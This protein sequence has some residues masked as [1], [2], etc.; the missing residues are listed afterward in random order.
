MKNGGRKKINQKEKSEEN[1]T[2]LLAKN[3]VKRKIQ[4]LHDPSLSFFLF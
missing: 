3:F 1:F 4:S 2:K